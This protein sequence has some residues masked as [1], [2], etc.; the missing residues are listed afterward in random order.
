M[1]IN[2]TQAQII[3]EYKG[4]PGVVKLSAGQLEA[5]GL[6]LPAICGG[7]VTIQKQEP[8]KGL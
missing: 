3:I 5:L 2:V 1:N 6:Y 8:M 7:N 4:K